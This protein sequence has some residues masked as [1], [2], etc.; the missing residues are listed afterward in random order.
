MT[1]I[2]TILWIVLFAIAGWLI[3]LGIWAVIDGRN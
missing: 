2:E 3:G 1:P